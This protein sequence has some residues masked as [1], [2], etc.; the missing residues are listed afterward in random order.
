MMPIYKKTRKC[1]SWSLWPFWQG[2][3]LHKKSQ[4]GRSPPESPGSKELKTQDLIQSLG[5]AESSMPLC[6][7]WLDQESRNGVMLGRLEF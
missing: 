3:F 7:S 6:H 5:N 4:R 2:I 1:E